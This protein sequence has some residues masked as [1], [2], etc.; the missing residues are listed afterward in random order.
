MQSVKAV[1]IPAREVKIVRNTRAQSKHSQWAQIQ[2][3]KTGEVLHTG[4]I[5]Y[6]RRVARKRYNRL[7]Q[8]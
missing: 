8:L 1:V 7:A 6:I 3:A 5:G 2:D 4:Q